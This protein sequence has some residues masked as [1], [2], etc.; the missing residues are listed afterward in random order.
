MKIIAAKDFTLKGVTYK[1]GEEIKPPKEYLIKLNEEG[2]IE[3]IDIKDI[4]KY[5]EKTMLKDEKPKSKKE[6]VQ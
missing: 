6:E 5:D 1:K 4:D 3:P 2:Y